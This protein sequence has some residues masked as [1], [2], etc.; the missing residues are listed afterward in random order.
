VSFDVSLVSCGTAYFGGYRAAELLVRNSNIWACEVK[1]KG[2]LAPFLFQFSQH[3]RSSFKLLSRISFIVQRPVRGARDYEGAPFRF[4]L[5][6]C[7]KSI[8]GL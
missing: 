1:I 6:G 4:L 8:S 7:G 3:G 5:S 2:L